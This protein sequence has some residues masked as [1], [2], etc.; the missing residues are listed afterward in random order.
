MSL[1]VASLVTCSVPPESVTSTDAKELAG[2]SSAKAAAVASAP[3][4][5]RLRRLP[6]GGEEV[7]L[8]SQSGRVEPRA[9]VWVSL[10]CGVRTL[11]RSERQRV[12]LLAAGGA[13]A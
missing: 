7:I 1:P 11:S 6:C 12:N 5:Q 8:I 10:P 4:K 3:T 13:C 2:A 9:T